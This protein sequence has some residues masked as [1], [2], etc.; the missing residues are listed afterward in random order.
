MLFSLFLSAALADDADYTMGADGSND[1]FCESATAIVVDANSFTPGVESPSGYDSIQVVYNFLL[2]D[3]D[4]VCNYEWLST[5]ASES[6]LFPNGRED[7]DYDLTGDEFTAYI[8]ESLYEA[9]LEG[10]RDSTLAVFVDGTS[11]NL[12]TQSV[13]IDSGESDTGDDKDSVECGGCNQGITFA[14]TLLFPLFGFR[15]RK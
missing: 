9:W 15:R 6:D 7:F 5:W 13:E 1:A 3:G 10:N 11:V 8:P 14:A 2:D 4:E 12:Y